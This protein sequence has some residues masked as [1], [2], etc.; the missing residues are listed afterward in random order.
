MKTT[1]ARSK[2]ALIA[3]GLVVALAA[4]STGALAWGNS[5]RGDRDPSQR[6]EYIFNQL[7]LTEAQSTEVIEVMESFRDAQRDAR[8]ERRESGEERPSEE[9]REAMKEQAQQQLADELGTVLQPTQVEDLMEYLEFH[10]KGKCDK[11][12]GGRDHHRDEAHQDRDYEP[13]ATE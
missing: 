7:D 11:R 1:F 6:F 5:D 12:H 10:G 9:E 4:G 8:Q 13:E 3:T 2:N